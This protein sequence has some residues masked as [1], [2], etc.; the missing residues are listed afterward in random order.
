VNSRQENEVDSPTRVPLKACADML[1]L[2]V[3]GGGSTVC[4]GKYLA[5]REILVFVAGTSTVWDF[6][7][8]GKEWTI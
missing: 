2:N 5:E 3:F 1:H 7:P 6:S 4:K 8:V